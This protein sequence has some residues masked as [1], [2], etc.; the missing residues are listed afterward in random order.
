VLVDRGYSHRPGWLTCWTLG[1]RWWCVGTQARFLWKIGRVG[2]STCCRACAPWLTAKWENGR[3]VCLPAKDLRPAAVCG[4]QSRLAAEQARRKALRK[5]Q[6]NGTQ[7]QTEALELTAYVLVLTSAD[8]KLFLAKAVLDLYRGRGKSNWCSS[9][10][11][12]SSRRAR[13]QER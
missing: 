7:A 10:S 4:A 12:A 6:K 1:R 3:T 9:G 11:R 5:A 8:A 13:A 2:R